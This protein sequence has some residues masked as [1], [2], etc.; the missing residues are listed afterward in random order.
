[1]LRRGPFRSMLWLGLLAGGV[2]GCGDHND[3][4]A[5]V[6]LVRPVQ[7]VGDMYR[8][9]MMD[10]KKPPAKPQDFRPYQ[11]ATPEGY[12]WVSDGNIVVVWGVALTDLAPEGSKD[13]PDEVLAYE[14]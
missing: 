10:H 14:K 5:A 13:S 6:A 4:A 9:Y 12:R 2:P 11:D 3:T 1:M 7:D 8:M